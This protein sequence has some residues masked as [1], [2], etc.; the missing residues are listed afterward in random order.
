MHLNA[1]IETHSDIIHF[2]ELQYRSKVSYHRLERC[3]FIT[4]L[5]D[6]KAIY[7]AVVCIVDSNSYG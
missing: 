4:P 5:V 2:F 3:I 7:K 6:L 1:I